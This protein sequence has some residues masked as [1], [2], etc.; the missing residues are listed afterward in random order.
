M[1]SGC[2]LTGQVTL[3]LN[4]HFYAAVDPAGWALFHVHAGFDVKQSLVYRYD[5]AYRSNQLNRHAYHVAS[6]GFLVSST[7]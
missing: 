2:G 1:S 5:I 3:F 6:D 4:G 7:L